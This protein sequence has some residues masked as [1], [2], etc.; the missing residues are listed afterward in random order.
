MFLD[1]S[2]LVSVDADGKINPKEEP[3]AF[4]FK[5]LTFMELGVELIFGDEIYILGKAV[6]LSDILNLPSQDIYLSSL[7]DNGVASDL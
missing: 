1:G 5:H 6:R 2:V 7:D 4:L 3:Y